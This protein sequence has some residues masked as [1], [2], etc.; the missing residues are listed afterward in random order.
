MRTSST[1]GST[2]L[3]SRERKVSVQGGNVGIEVIWGGGNGK[4]KWLAE[5]GGGEKI[6][7]RKAVK[8]DKRKKDRGRNGRNKTEKYYEQGREGW[9]RKEEKERGGEGSRSKRKQGQGELQIGEE[10]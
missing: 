6:R 2:R 1:L 3:I 10:K 4:T 7:G 5:K 9:V 8:R